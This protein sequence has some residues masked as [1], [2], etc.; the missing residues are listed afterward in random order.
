MADACASRAQA[1]LIDAG[2]TDGWLNAI[3]DWVIARR[4]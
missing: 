4:N 2:L 1:V 3:A